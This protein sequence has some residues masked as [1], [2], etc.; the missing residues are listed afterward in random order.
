MAYTTSLN[1][2]N[3]TVVGSSASETLASTQGDGE[4]RINSYEGND[5]VTV[6]LYESG[7][8][9]MGSGTDTVIFD[10]G[11]SNVAVSLGDAAD[12][13]NGNT[14]DP[15]TVGGQGGADNFIVDAVSEESRYAGGRGI[16]TFQVTA[17]ATDATL[18]G[19][20]EDDVFTFGTALLLMCLSTVRLAQI[21]SRSTQ[22]HWQ[23]HNPWWLKV[24]P[25]PSP[26]TSTTAVFGDVGADDITDGAGDNTLNGGDGADTIDSGAGVDTIIGGGVQTALRSPLPSLELLRVQSPSQLLTR[27]EPTF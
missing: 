16:D 24:T 8:I 2:G 13:F 6:G 1:D 27:P 20:S 26:L 25:S 22:L 9:G 10:A 19:G 7:S 17:A 3:L 15:V 11:V 5:Q 4:V 18:V 21:K 23:Q 14:D 12:T